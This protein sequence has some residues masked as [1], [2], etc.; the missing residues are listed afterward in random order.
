MSLIR[1]PDEGGDTMVALDTGDIIGPMFAKSAEQMKDVFDNIPNFS[2]RDDDVMLCTFP[3]TGTNWVFEVIMML[4][5]GLADRIDRSKVTTMLEFMTHD[6]VN[7]V[8]S[9]RVINTHYHPRFLPKDMATKKIKTVLC[10]RNPK[11]TAVSYYNHMTGIRFYDYSGKWENWIRPFIH[12][13]YELGTYSAYLNEW[14]EVIEAGTGFP[15][16]VIY[17]EDLKKVT[18][19]KSTRV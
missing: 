11:D 14:Q 5:R 13:K 9:P 12:G 10:V 15:L 16:H 6:E 17:F 3:K 19:L 8:P 4:M 1:I 7:S 2:C 18:S